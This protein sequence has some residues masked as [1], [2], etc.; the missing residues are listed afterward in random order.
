MKIHANGVPARVLLMKYVISKSG[1][2]RQS[3]AL[4]SLSFL[5]SCI[6]LFCGIHFIYSFYFVNFELCDIVTLLQN[7]HP[8]NL[9]G[10][11]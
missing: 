6:S 5:Q 9:D 7:G 11:V 3:L 1:P 2:K 4:G 10:G 8:C